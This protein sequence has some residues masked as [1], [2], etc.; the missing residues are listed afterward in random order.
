MKLFMRL[1]TSLVTGLSL[2]WSVLAIGAVIAWLTA[3]AFLGVVFLQN[4][5]PQY[6]PLYR[7]VFFR[8]MHC[9]LSICY[10]PLCDIFF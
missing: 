9:D 10:Q 5:A 4:S 6:L 1:I 2:A 8:Q 7:K 3:P